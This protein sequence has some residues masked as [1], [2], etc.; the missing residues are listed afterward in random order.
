MD[1]PADRPA[2]GVEAAISVAD[3]SALAPLARRLVSVLPRPAFVA[4]HGDLGAG[5]TTFVRAV[6]AASGID[7]TEVISPTFGLIHEHAGPA[8]GLLHADMY[9]L[10]GSGAL[11]EIGW[12]DAVA[13]AACVFVEWPERIADTLPADRLDV[14]I[15]ID[16]PTAR[17]L[18]FIGHGP[19]HAAAVLQLRSP[20]H[21]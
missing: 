16:S 15:A 19:L 3:E 17:T 6:A 8:G 21:P 10:T 1:E 18:R 13:R 12:D 14:M 4:L 7:P 5:K 11:Y 2:S 20:E 9:R